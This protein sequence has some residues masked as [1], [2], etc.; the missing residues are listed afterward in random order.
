M[1]ASLQRLVGHV[2]DT[3]TPL[4]AL[5]QRGTFLVN[6]CRLFNHEA[7]LSVML[8]TSQISQAASAMIERTAR[9]PPTLAVGDY[10]RARYEP[11]KAAARRAPGASKMPLPARPPDSPNQSPRA[12]RPLFLVRGV[13][14]LF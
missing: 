14:P 11:R 7:P 2:L 6:A 8:H 3:L 1:E 4:I 5:S 12:Q 10:L 13:H 9:P